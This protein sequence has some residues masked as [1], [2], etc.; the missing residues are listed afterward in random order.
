M[1]NRNLDWWV[2]D[3]IFE[4]MIQSRD[5]YE[6]IMQEYNIL[7]VGRGRQREEKR[8]EEREKYFWYV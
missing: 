8:G 1:E 4:E 6:V 7:E 3:I 2:R 5:Q